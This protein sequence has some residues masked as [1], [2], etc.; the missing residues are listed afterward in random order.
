MP[1]PHTAEVLSDILVECLFDWNLDR[2]LSTLTVDN[3]STNDAMIER[4]FDRISPSSFILRGTLFH[5][6]CCAHI[7]NLIVRD[8]MSTIYASIEKIR[9]SVVYWVATPKREEKFVETCRQLN[10]DYSKKLALDCRT[11][12]NS[13]YLMLVSALPYQEVFKRF[14]TT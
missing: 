8:G 5:M 6:R 12:W 10:V 9:E 4:V 3:C 14:K 2:K 11:R 1:A 13:T 7:I